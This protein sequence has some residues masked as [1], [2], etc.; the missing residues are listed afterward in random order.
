VLADRATPQEG[1]GRTF[2]LLV[3]V[4]ALGAALDEESVAAGIEQL[5]GVFGGDGRAL[6]LR[7][8]LGADVQHLLLLLLL[9]VFCSGHGWLWLCGV[10]VV[11]DWSVRSEIKANSRPASSAVGANSSGARGGR[12]KRPL[13]SPH[14]IN[15]IK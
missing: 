9:L 14:K 4:D 6:L 2:V 8:D 11:E 13:K 15:K 10:V 3:L 1:G 12:R 5:L 7:L